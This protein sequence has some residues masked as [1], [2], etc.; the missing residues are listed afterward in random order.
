[1]AEQVPDGFEV[2]L[3]RVNGRPGL[4]TTVDGAPQSVRAFDVRAGHIQNAYAVLSLDKLRH[5]DP[6]SFTSSS[7]GER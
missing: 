4:L 2:S 7:E 5:V 3:V 6:A 1:M